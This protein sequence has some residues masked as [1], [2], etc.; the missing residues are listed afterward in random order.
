MHMLIVREQNIFHES[1]N[2]PHWTVCENRENCKRVSKVF[3]KIVAFFMEWFNS[4]HS[5]MNQLLIQDHL[6][7]HC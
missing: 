4:H 6:Y 1:M 5:M 7:Q 2:N 3:A